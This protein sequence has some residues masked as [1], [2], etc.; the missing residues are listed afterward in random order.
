MSPALAG[1]FFT[2]EPAG[3]PCDGFSKTPSMERSLPTLSELLDSLAPE[4]FR[5]TPDSP[6]RAPLES[7][8]WSRFQ[9]HSCPS[10]R[11]RAAPGTQAVISKVTVDWRTQD[12]SRA[13]TNVSTLSVQP[14]SRINA[15]QAVSTVWLISTLFKKL[16]IFAHF[17]VDFMEEAMSVILT[18][19][20]SLISLTLACVLNLQVNLNFSQ[21]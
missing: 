8:S 18:L 3:K 11:W 21:I 16:T 9:L 2:T 6:T 12:E 20:F 13:K 14:Y 10:G 17:P 1:G 5:E 4:G 7:V 19:T 15:L